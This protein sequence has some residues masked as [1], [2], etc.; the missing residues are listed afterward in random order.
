MSCGSAGSSRQSD[1]LRRAP[2][3]LHFRRDG[4]TSTHNP[5]CARN[6]FGLSQRQGMGLHTRQAMAH[7]LD[8]RPTVEDFREDSPWVQL[9]KTHWLETSKVRK[10]KPDTIKKDI[11]DPLEADGFNFRSLLALENLNILE[12]FVCC[13]SAWC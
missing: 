4:T 7:S 12:K 11:W 9:A 6:R 8:S 1:L 10:V 3:A 5:L 2:E 13:L